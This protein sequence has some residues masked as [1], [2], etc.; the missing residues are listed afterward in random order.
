MWSALP[1]QRFLKIRISPAFAVK[2]DPGL[3]LSRLVVARKSNDD[4]GAQRGIA[5]LWTQTIWH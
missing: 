4:C 5:M 1:C 2:F 3:S